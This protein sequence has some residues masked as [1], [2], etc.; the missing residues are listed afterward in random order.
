MSHRSLVVRSLFVIAA[1]LALPATASELPWSAPAPA[2]PAALTPT[3]ELFANGLDQPGSNRCEGCWDQVKSF[4]ESDV[5]CGGSDCLPCAPGLHCTV[6]GD[7]SSQ[8]CNPSSS[9]CS[10][11]SCSDAVANGSETDVDC[12]GPLCA[13]CADHLHC[14][15]NNDCQ[16][17]VCDQSNAS[18]ASP[19]CSDAVRN[20]NETD[21]DCGGGTC[22]TCANGKHCQVNGDCQSGVCTAGTQTCAIPTCSDAVKNGGETDIDCGGPTCNKCGSGKR[23]QVGADCVS[24]ICGAGGICQ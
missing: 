20:A 3:C 14:I 1:L 22:P 24:G 4:S 21:I 9:T 17:R 18:C 8:V 10:A 2:L 5:D 12:G 23:C 11:P 16:S 19:T 6:A 7:C 15:I 13:R